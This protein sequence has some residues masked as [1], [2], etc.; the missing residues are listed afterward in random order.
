MDMGRDVS[1]DLAAQIEALEDDDRINDEIER[2]KTEMSG[3]E[4]E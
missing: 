2:L 3:R 1:P 4:G